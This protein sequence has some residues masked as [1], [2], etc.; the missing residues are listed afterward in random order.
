ML[1]I[2][3]VTRSR[4]S[5]VI[6]LCEELGLAYDQVPVIQR[7]RID[8][9]TA[10][11]VVHTRSPAF[12]DINPNGH[13]P[14]IDDDGLVLHES[15]AITL[16]LARKHGG[17]LAPATVAEEGL[18]VMWSLWA[19]TEVE[20]AALAVMQGRDVEANLSAL[21][22]PFRVLDD[23]LA[24]DGHLVGGRFT[25]ADLNVA[26]VVRYA[27]AAPGLMDAHP[28]VAAWYAAC[29]DR[30]AFRAMWAKRETEPA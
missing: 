8:E 10:A 30:P 1:K 9:A 5:R 24:G 25:V 6:W 7:Y 23:A 2:Y 4:A 26:E 21:Q 15:L 17:P 19:A 22:A 3:G 29:H 18:M 27:A 14:S 13:V 11:K 20:F 28:A 12:L 16:Y